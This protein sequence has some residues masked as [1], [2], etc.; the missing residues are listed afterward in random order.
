MISGFFTDSIEVSNKSRQQKQSG[1][2]LRYLSKT[3]CG[4]T[5][6]EISDYV[7]ISVPTTTKL[8]HDLIDK[9]CVIEV[10]KKETDNGRKPLLYSINKECFYALGVEVVLNRIQVKVIRIDKEVIF[11]RKDDNFTL[12]NT[13]DCLNNVIEFIRFAIDNCGVEANQLMGIGVG[14]TGRVD[15]NT[16]DTLNYFNFLEKSFAKTLE[17][18]LGL[19]TIVDNDTRVLGIAEQVVGK[20]RNVNNAL[21]VNVSRGLGISLILNKKMIAGGN[22]FAGEFGHMQFRQSNRLCLCGKKGCLGTVVSGYALEQDMA[23]A[24]NG[25]EQSIHFNKEQG[26]NYLYC[27]VLDAAL[28]GDALSIKIIQKQGEALGEALGNLLNLL[29]PE[30]I[31]IG[32]KIAKAGDLFSTSVNMGMKKTALINPL[33]F[34]KIRLSELEK[35]A[36]PNGAA[37]MLWKKYEM[38]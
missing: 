7:R 31:I 17:G 28:K 10:G 6:P 16:G 14:I 9:Q 21:V 2:I 30:V 23:E 18:N 4:L 3:Q 19:P 1:R 13:V 25:G 29:N 36:V 27:D 8:I 38:I 20:A 24:L 22:G 11:E 37:Y 26:G 12:E 32:G 15:C 35:E 33:M 5:I 34:C